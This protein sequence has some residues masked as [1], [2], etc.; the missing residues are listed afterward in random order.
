VAAP[1]PL[2]TY[3]EGVVNRYFRRLQQFGKSFSARR[4]RGAMVDSQSELFAASTPQDVTSVRAKSSGH[5]KR[6]ADK[7][8]Q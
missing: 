3:G 4:S 7:W 8:N 6:T 5:R 1:A 2:E